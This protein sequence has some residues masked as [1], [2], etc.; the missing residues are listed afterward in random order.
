MIA[1]RLTVLSA[2][3]RGKSSSCAPASRATFEASPRPLVVLCDSWSGPAAAL[4]EA[5]ALA[6][7]TDAR[8]LPDTIEI[9]AAEHGEIYLLLD[10]VEEYFVYHGSDPALGTRSPIS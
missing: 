4:T 9:A 2:Q 10:Q 8:S 6:S 3:R 5:V 7:A 1:S